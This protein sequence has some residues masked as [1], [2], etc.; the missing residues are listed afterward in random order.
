MAGRHA[1]RQEFELKIWKMTIDIEQ[2][3]TLEAEVERLREALAWFLD[4]PRFQVAVSFASSV[5]IGLR[6]VKRVCV[7]NMRGTS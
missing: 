3:A 4:D 2:I 6:G 1:D 5:A 7:K